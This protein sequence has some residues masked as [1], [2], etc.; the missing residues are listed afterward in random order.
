MKLIIEPTSTVSAR[1]TLDGRACTFGYNHPSGKWIFQGITQK[2]L[3]TTLGG[4]ALQLL[5]K[6]LPAMLQ[7]SVPEEPNPQGDA[8]GTWENLPD[9][10]VRETTSI[11]KK[12]LQS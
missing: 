6:S 11:Q 8:W 1:I 7:A 4:L 10:L 5:A 9:R 3:D 12:H 2:E